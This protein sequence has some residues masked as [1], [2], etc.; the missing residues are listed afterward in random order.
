M[1]NA[2]VENTGNNTNSNF[3]ILFFLPIEQNENTVFQYL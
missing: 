3:M 2:K 1:C